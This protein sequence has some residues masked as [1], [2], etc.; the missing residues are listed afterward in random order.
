MAAKEE[1]RKQ[2]VHFELPYRFVLGLFT[3]S[4]IRIGYLSIADLFAINAR[5]LVSA[6]TLSLAFNF[7]NNLNRDPFIGDA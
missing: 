6:S 1:E 3:Q 4:L 7:K 2:E 5:H